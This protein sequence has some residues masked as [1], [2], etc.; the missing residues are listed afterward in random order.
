MNVIQNGAGFIRQGIF[1]ELL[2]DA[3][4]VFHVCLGFSANP[5]DAEELLQEVYL[6]AW[7]DIGSLKTHSSARQWLLR[8]ARN[9]SLNHLRKKSSDTRLLHEGEFPLVEKDTPEASIIRKEQYLTLKGAVRRLPKKYREVFVM[10]EY[11]QLSYEEIS[12]TLGIKAGTVMSRL[13]RARQ[14]VLS[15]LRENGYGK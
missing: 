10:R 12:E 14:A 4:L 1:E 5:L 15:C 8:I 13:N 3:G 7:S 11:G 9:M 6:K 2:K